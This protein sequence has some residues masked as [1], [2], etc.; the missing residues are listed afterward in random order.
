MIVCL[1]D[2]AATETA[3]SARRGRLV[4]ENQFLKVFLLFFFLT[5]A[6][7]SIG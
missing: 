6:Q 2:S 7:G 4:T 3:E 5:L 1:A